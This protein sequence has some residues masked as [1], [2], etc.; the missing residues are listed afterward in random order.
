MPPLVGGPADT[1]IAVRELEPSDPE[2]R[3]EP[4]HR[5]RP[6][7]EGAEMRLAILTAA[8]HLFG[9]C[10]YDGVSMEDLAE[11]CG[12]EPQALQDYFSSKRELFDA[13]A[14]ESARRFSVE[15]TKRV[16]GTRA[17][18][19]RMH[20]YIDAYRHLY[21]SDPD[22]LPFI[23]MMLVDSLP[24]TPPVSRAAGSK[25]GLM[26]H[27]FA[28][29]LVDEALGND[30]LH[31]AIDREGAVNLITAIGSGLALASIRSDRREFLSML[32]AFDRLNAGKL[33]R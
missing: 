9:Q 28:E 17:F 32:D 20:G 21:Q 29:R 22:L 19:D 15:I 33:Y 13:V 4:T 18:R 14:A 23:G 6:A 3:K 11:D 30:E 2:D 27:G 12:I 7:S 16:L 5:R 1:V 10:G 24:D 26:P 25:T 31:E 8:R